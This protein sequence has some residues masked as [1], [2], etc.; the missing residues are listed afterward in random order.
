[1]T[2]V[3]RRAH[4]SGATIVHRKA[5][6]SSSA[7]DRK[8]SSSSSE[9]DEDEAKSAPAGPSPMIGRIL[10]RAMM[11]FRVAHG[12]QSPSKY[13]QAQMERWRQVRAA[14]SKQPRSKL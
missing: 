2:L 4:R 5:D 7:G 1:M 9:A 10:S 3:Q 14:Q 8:H 6:T 13:A 11:R 12:E